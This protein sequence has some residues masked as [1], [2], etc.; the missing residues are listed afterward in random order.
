MINDFFIRMNI[1]YFILK[2]LTV[3]FTYIKNVEKMNISG[4][5]DLLLALHF[6]NSSTKG[7]RAMVW[8]GRNA[9]MD[10]VLDPRIESIYEDVVKNRCCW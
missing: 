9:I 4:A 10:M 7:I 8:L 6:S 3:K 2:S 1:F 5:F